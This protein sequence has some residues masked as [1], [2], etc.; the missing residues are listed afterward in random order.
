MLILEIGEICKFGFKCPYAETCQGLK[1]NRLN[2]FTCSF[3]DKNNNIM[4]GEIRLKD[5]QT[6]KMKVIMG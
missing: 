4:N 5:D 2:K 1:K 3:R 6:G